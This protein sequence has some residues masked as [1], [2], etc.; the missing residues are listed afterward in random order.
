MGKRNRNK[1]RQQQQQ[2]QQQ[3]LTNLAPSKQPTKGPMEV[4]GEL[5]YGASSHK[6]AFWLGV[7]FAGFFGYQ[8]ARFYFGLLQSPFGVMGL[9]ALIG[10]IAITIA[11]TY[12]EVAPVIRRKSARSAFEALFRIAAK[13]QQRPVITDTQYDNPQ[14]LYDR[15]RMA[16]KRYEQGSNRN[17]WIVIAVEIFLGLVFMGAVG[18]GLK[19]LGQLVLFVASIFGTEH[20]L[21][22]A[23]RAYDMA[24]PPAIRQQMDKLLNNSDQPLKLH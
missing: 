13:P 2:A 12:F 6:G 23:I 10:G 4:V 9:G 1:Q 21:V 14:E 18:T 17:R 22:M 3:G 16:E 20:G 8:N 15:H 7:S 11:T 19:A 24:L 5:I